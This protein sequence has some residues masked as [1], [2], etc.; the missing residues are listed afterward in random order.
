MEIYTRTIRLQTFG[1]CDLVN[2]T[3][4]V[5]TILNDAKIRNGVVNVFVSGST[6]AVTTIEYEPN[7]IKDFQELMEKLI[8]QDLPTHHGQTWG[9]DNGF[10]HLR[11]SLIGPSLSVPVVSGKLELGT[12][13]QITL[14]DFDNRRR[15][16]E[17]IIQIIGK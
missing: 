3:S 2:I 11:A 12:W 17:V 7:L 4:Q 6:A 14:C 1:F 9:D 16:R 15:E 13:Q 5:E 10:A 8:S